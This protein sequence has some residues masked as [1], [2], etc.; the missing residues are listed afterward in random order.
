M[1]SFAYEQ[2]RVEIECILVSFM[3]FLILAEVEAY[4]VGPIFLFKTYKVYYVVHYGS[5]ARIL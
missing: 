4:F 2:F 1:R 5:G 3:L